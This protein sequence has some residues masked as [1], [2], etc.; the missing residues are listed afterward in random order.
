MIA[1]PIRKTRT[2]PAG[3]NN[4]EAGI[5]RYPGP[6]QLWSIFAGSGHRQVSHAGGRDKVAAIEAVV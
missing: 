3:Y 1:M 4:P 6:V 2:C 5:G